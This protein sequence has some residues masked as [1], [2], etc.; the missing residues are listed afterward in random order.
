MET[1]QIRVVL[2]LLVFAGERCSAAQTS[3]KD[4]KQDQQ[5]LQQP[6][7]SQSSAGGHYF[8]P[9]GKI[10]LVVNYLCFYH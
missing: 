9:L 7:T 8:N 10:G 6:V 3:S 4:S 5:L 2:I 1:E